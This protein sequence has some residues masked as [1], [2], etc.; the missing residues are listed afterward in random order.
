MTVI[1]ENR[2][3]RAKNILNRTAK[4]YEKREKERERKKEKK[5]REVELC[6]RRAY[7]FAAHCYVLC[8]E[9]VG[10][11]NWCLRDGR[12]VLVGQEEDLVWFWI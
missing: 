10:L 8:E 12:L 1:E 11:L 2:A 3:E 9:P 7:P 5:V 6:I 4:G